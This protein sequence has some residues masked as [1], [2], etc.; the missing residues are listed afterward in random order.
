MTND[1]FLCNADE[2]IHF[3]DL[4]IS[5]HSLMQFDTFS[6][7]PIFYDPQVDPI[8]CPRWVLGQ[9]SNCLFVHYLY[10]D[11][12]EPNTDNKWEDRRR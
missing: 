4:R 11:D 2:N 1:D 12:Q 8:C 6:M 7:Y 10:N 9:D 3:L 5:A